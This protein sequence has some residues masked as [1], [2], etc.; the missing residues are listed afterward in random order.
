MYGTALMGQNTLSMSWGE[1]IWAA[2]SVGRAELLHII[3]HGRF[4]SFEIAYRVSILFANLCEDENGYLERSSAYEG[5]DPSEKSAISYFLGLTLTKA[6]GARLLNVPWLMH[7]DV[8]REDLQPIFRNSNSRPD[9]VGKNINDEWVIME[10]KGR[11]NGFD[12]KALQ[13][14]KDQA[15]QVIEISGETPILHV[16]LQVHFNNGIMCLEVDDPEPNKKKGI[17]LPISNEKFSDGY[18]RPFKEWLS[19]G[20]VKP[21]RNTRYRQ[22]AIAEFDINVGIIDSIFEMRESPLRYGIEQQTSEGSLPLESRCQVL[23]T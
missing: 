5:L 18:Y 13:K 3:R 1:L 2:I 21:F 8:Y 19:D 17:K 10:A 11:T 20:E 15:R 4:S 22:R 23:Y 9:L 12:R 16:G 6:F 14:A 7:L